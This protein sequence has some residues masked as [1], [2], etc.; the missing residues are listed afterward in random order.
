MSPIETSTKDGTS[1]LREDVEAHC[2]TARVLEND[3][4]QIEREQDHLKQE[5]SKLFHISQLLSCCCLLF[6]NTSRCRIGAYQLANLLLNASGDGIR[7][8]MRNWVNLE[9][10]VGAI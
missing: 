2:S 5:F 3:E 10:I 8:L 1:V 4:S 6:L 9:C 7:C